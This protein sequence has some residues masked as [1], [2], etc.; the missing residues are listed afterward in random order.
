MATNLHGLLK[1]VAESDFPYM[2]RL[3]HVFVGGSELHGAK[4][5]GTDDLDIDGVYV[6]PPKLVLGLETLPH[7]V[8]STAGNERQ[9]GPADVDVTL[10]SLRKW[11]GM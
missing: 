5:H 9:N 1:H 4:V 10:Y 6:E 2:E 11:A 8:W 7:Y 3:I